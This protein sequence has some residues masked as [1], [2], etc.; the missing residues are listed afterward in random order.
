MTR[1]FDFYE[2]AAVII[3]GAVLILGLIYFFP[4][5]RDLWGKDGLSFGEFGI[6][7]ILAYAVGHLVQGI[8]N[9][10]ERAFWPVFGD[11]PTTQIIKKGKHLSPSQHTLLLKAIKTDFGVTDADLNKP[12]GTLQ[13][14]VV[15]AIYGAVARANRTQRVDT[16][17][18]N[19]GLS[20]GLAA[21][22]LVLL[23]LSAYPWK[24]TLPP[25][26]LAILLV[27]SLQR[28]RRFGWHY[29]S[30][31]ITEYLAIK[32]PNDHHVD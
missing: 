24:A 3:P 4:E 25:I 15:R 6:F 23:A 32:R 30:E 2:Y 29:G 8:G 7:V 28:M 11:L 19:H 21:T 14:P 20:R 5:G 9:Y 13:L 17:L 16:F 1:N 22:F 18:G 27:I 26:A 12:T 10:I 31:L